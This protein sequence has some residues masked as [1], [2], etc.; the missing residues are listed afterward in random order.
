MA[1]DTQDNE[2]FSFI[3]LS[4]A[5]ENVIRYLGLTEQKKERAKGY[6]SACHADE[7]NG[8]DNLEHIDGNLK[9]TERRANIG[10]RRMAED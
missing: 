2:R 1:R 8:A 6:A 9:E 7:D 10:K 3:T 4:A 5:T